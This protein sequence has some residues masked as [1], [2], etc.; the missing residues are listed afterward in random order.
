MQDLCVQET[1]TPPPPLDSVRR[2][3]AISL[4]QA[5]EAVLEQRPF[6]RPNAGF[7]RQL[8]DYERRLFNRTSVRMAR[9]SSGVLPEAVE[10]AA[11]VY[12][13]NI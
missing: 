10:D 5:H 8:V 9:T 6:I 11:A 3:E 13:I 2:F 4:C 1:L 12:S 7:W